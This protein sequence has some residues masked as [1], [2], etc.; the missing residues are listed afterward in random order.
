M[1][2]C[3]VPFCPRTSRQ[4]GEEWIC[5]EHW[6]AVPRMTKLRLR[7]SARF[8]RK[9]FGDNGWWTYPPGSPNRLA[10]VEAERRWSAA[11]ARCKAQAIEIAAG[12][13]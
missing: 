1:K 13:S 11:W 3:C 12:I 10:A 4:P 9:R 6:R 7:A 5:T 8:Y 2:R